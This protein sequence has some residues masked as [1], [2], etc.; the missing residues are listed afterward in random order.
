VPAARQVGSKR[1][2][3]FRFPFFFR[4]SVLRS[5]GSSGSSLFVI[6]GLDPAIHA[7]SPLHKWLASTR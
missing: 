5:F 6:A 7:A 4:P 1:L 2:S 3:A